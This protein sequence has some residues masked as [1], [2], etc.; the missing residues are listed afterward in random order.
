M[1][2]FQELISKGYI[3]RDIKPQNCLI[4]NNIFK[5]ADFGFATK[6]DLKGRKLLKDCVGTPLY[7]APQ[8]LENSSYTAKSD[9]WSI[10]MMFYEMI[11]GKTSPLRFP[12]DKPIGIQTKNFLVR[13]LTIDE[14]KRIGWD[15]IFQHSILKM[16]SGKVEVPEVVLDMK[17]KLIL[18]SMQKIVQM[19]NLNINNIFNKYDVD[20][21]GSLDENEFFYLLRMID[22]RI[23]EDESN[24]VFN[25]VDSSK[26]KKVT[27]QEFSTIFCNY[28]FSDIEDRVGNIITDLREI[29]KANGLKLKQMFVNFDT[30]Q[31]GTLD[32][33]EF[34]NLIKIVAPALK[35][36]EID[37]C[38]D[39]FDI[40]K[41]GNISFD[42]FVKALTVQE[43]GNNDLS[44][45]KAK[46]IIGELR[47]T[48]KQNNIDTHIIFNNITKKKEPFLDV[49]QFEKLIKIIDKNISSEDLKNAFSLFDVN[50]DGKIDYNEFNQIHI[51]EL[52]Y[53]QYQ[54]LYQYS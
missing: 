48:C 3:H 54:I 27:L 36:D 32:K 43:E 20:G 41:D 39:Q 9:L 2:G 28:D 45:Q 29:I 7:M 8:L 49:G 11:F 17:S 34:E 38:F 53:R 18:R 4:K 24:Y 30:D 50:N 42:E 16:E 22:K 5:I 37:Q 25:V 35:N 46:K 51:F 6:A 52:F 15:E 19:N 31:Y 10:G 26:D 47:K 12:Y 33:L 40:N 44:V 21:G 23:S 1:K 13:C 14:K